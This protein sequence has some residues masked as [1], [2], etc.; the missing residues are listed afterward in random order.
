MSIRPLVSISV[1]RFIISIVDP[2]TRT[3]ENT[4][5]IY[6]LLRRVYKRL[7]VAVI[8]LSSFFERRLDWIFSLPLAYIRKEKRL[9][10]KEKKQN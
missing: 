4:S 7:I 2:E 1:K 9:K 3:R 10:T 8:G 5:T 6:L